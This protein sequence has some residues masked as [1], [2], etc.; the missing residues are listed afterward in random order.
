MPMAA[1]TYNQ[2]HIPR[3]FTPG[4]RRISIYWT[5]SYPWES[6]R[7]IMEMDNRFSTM[8]EVRRVAWPFYET[9]DWSAAQFPAGDRGHA[10]TLPSLD[11]QLPEDRRRDD[12]PSRRCLPTYRSGGLQVADRRAHSRRHRHTHG[13]RARSSSL[14]TG[15]RAGGNR[16]HSR[17]AQTRR[18]LPAAWRRTTMS[19]S[20]SDLE[21]AP[22]GISSSRRPAGAAPAALRPIHTLVDERARRSRPQFYGLRPATFRVTKRHRAA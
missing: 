22:E 15:S 3:K 6:Q 21:A 12:R 14:G 8:T 1:R 10:G 7:D 9:P 4:K 11:A 2:D 17:L 5:W 18:N 16:R 19:A 13:V 20:T